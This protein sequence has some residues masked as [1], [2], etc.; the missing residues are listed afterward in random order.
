MKRK[1]FSPIII[2]VG[3]V[4]ILLSIGAVW[5][6]GFHRPSALGSGNANDGTIES[7]QY[8]SDFASPTSTWSTY[9]H[10]A[11]PSR[12]WD[13]NFSFQYPSGI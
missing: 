7:D 12:S 1:G 8:L 10:T 2:L 3:A 13:M 9:T 5:Y 6:Y 4:V 11:D